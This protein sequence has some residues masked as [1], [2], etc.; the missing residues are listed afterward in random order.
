MSGS[1]YDPELDDV[2]QDQE[3]VHL[4][5]LLSSARRA[6]PPLDEAFRSGLRRQLMQR[7]AGV[8]ERRPSWWSGLFAPPALAWAG[9]T[10]GVV[11]IAAVVVFV[12]LQPPSTVNQVVVGSPLDGANA[13]RLGQPIL[14]A[15][16]QPMDHASTQ[17]A[18]Q[19]TPATSVSFS[20][21]KSTVLAVQ[22]TSGNLAPNTQ[23][24]VTVGPTAKTATGAQ[25]LAAPST[26]T[27]V[28]QPPATPAPLPSPKPPPT[29]GTLLNAE[30]QVV[31]ISGGGMPSLQWTADSSS[32]YF[33][34]AG[35]ELEVVDLKSGTVNVVAQDS[36]S[37]PAIA[38]AGDRLAYVR[39]GNLEIVTFAT[40]TTAEVVVTP[41]AVVVGWAKDKLVWSASDGFYMQSAIGPAQ[42]S[43]LPSG[44]PVSATWIAP[45]GAHAVIQQDQKLLLLDLATGNSLQLGDTG[46]QFLGWS[47]D[48]TRL[49]YSSTSGTVVA[50]TKNT[51]IA[52]LQAGEP[53]WSSQDAILLGSDVELDQMRPDGSARSRLANGTYHAPS[54]APNGTTFAFFRGGALWTAN[55][56][57]LPPPPSSLDLA[58]VVVNSFMQARQQG[59]SD[60]A[61]SFLDE[62][63]KAA[64]A[65]GGL[66]LIPSGTGDQHFSRSYILTQELIATAPDTARFVVRLVL[67]QGKIDVSDFEETL[68]VVRDPATRSFLIDQA[69]GAS[70]RTLG[71]GPEVVG[72]D[73]G[74]T[75]IKLTF[76]SDLNPGTVTGGVLLLND[77]GKQLDAPVGYADRMVAITGLDLKPGMQYRLVVLTTVQDVVGSSVASEYGLDFFGPADTSHHG[78]SGGSPSPTP[79]PMPSPTPS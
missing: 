22:P 25:L 59:Q 73:V 44:G 3:L 2:L 68:T 4:A 23:Y 62:N 50:D 48:G 26:I 15:F 10:A 57:A 74:S 28:T 13:V 38:P 32:V 47:P 16:N 37:S 46:A 78:D 53:S 65:T 43:A 19:I 54:W 76:D 41:S 6:D 12:T 77:K 42:V 24:K 18:V 63:G 31:A 34:S 56:P 60:V 14:V 1:G 35:G 5:R 17:A 75:T 55:A 49:L 27:F 33:V 71:K 36:A 69:T 21:P 72:V 7:A 9:A 64:Y 45:D 20:W 52:T 30:H 51:V 29:P 67:A 70:S 79:S 61:M 58:S 11:L 66:T 8:E 40:G 39:G